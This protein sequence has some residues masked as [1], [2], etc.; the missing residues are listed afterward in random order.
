MLGN[1]LKENLDLLDT[2]GNMFRKMSTIDDFFDLY[3]A[4]HY[5]LKIRCQETL[6]II[7]VLN[8]P[9]QIEKSNE[10]PNIIT[11]D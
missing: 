11:N 4:L 1:L 10:I 6:S 8:T 5:E 9:L 7:A 2:F 3:E